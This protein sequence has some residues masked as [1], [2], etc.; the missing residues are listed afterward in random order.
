MKRGEKMKKLS[1]MKL[2]DIFSEETI[3]SYAYLS[4][5]KSTLSEFII[6]YI[7]SQPGFISDKEKELTR[8]K[9]E[10]DFYVH[11]INKKTLTGKP[12]EVFMLL[13]DP[14]P[15]RISITNGQFLPDMGEF[16]TILHLTLIGKHIRDIYNPGFRFIICY[17]GNYFKDTGG[18]TKEETMKV[19]EIIQYYKEVAEK[20][21]KIKNVI[22][23]VD[24]EELIEP[25][26]DEHYRL[27]E[28]KKK[29]VKENKNLYQEFAKY[30]FEEVINTD[31]YKT[32]EEAKEK[33]KEE[34]IRMVAFGEV[35][36]KGG[37]KNNGIFWKYPH[38]ISANANMGYREE[39][40]EF[41]L[42]PDGIT[43]PYNFITTRNKKGKWEL[44]RYEDIKDKPYKKV[45]VE[46]F[47]H[48]FYY[49]EV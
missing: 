4:D 39:A 12:I 34:A 36:D 11:L 20:M 17:E 28:E 23:F 21:V 31:D 16:L 45:Y 48:V 5:P 49:Q 7:A 22:S 29:K 43:I 8:S 13:F 42:L 37:E 19:Y 26:K 6:D 38:V 30:M 18:F 33:A 15:R 46:E 9:E 32:I 44:K 24:L 2:T 1:E 3:D 10:R 47:D 35:L 14:K 41:Q 27:L 25:F 40:F